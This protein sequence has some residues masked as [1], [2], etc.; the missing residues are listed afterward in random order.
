M[1]KKFQLI[2]HLA[3]EAIER[4]YRGSRDG[5]ERSHWQIIWLLAQGQTMVQIAA[6]T[7][8]STRWIR[9]T[10]TAMDQAG[11]SIESNLHA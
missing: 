1:G 3:I 4:R 6:T 10:C 2:A 7:G 11:G 9:A 8:Y 5:V